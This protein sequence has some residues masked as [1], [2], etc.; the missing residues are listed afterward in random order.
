MY[1]KNC[2]YV[3]AHAHEIMEELFTRTILNQAVILWRGADGKF[4]AE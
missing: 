3:A 1:P 4:A 2:W